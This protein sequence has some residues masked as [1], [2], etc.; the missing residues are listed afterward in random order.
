MTNLNYMNK[1]LLPLV[2]LSFSSIGLVQ[3]QSQCIPSNL[4]SDHLE[5]PIGID[6][7]SP[8]SGIIYIP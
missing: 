5:N 6:N 1:L 7:P 2:F 4:K 8:R 3:G